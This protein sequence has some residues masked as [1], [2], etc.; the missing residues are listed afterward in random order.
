MASIDAWEHVQAVLDMLDTASPAHPV[1]VG[2]VVE[3]NP[4]TPYWLVL[5]DAGILD[6]ETLAGASS[7]IDMRVVVKS[8]GATAREAI[9]A[10]QAARAV[11][12]DARP[13]VAGRRCWPVRHTDTLPVMPDQGVTT[14]T[15]RRLHQAVD[16]FRIASVPA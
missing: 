15:S 12:V 11:L 2:E 16:T 9:A 7:R 8:V 6:G 10:A 13:V 5:P 1:H 14:T 3:D 4:P